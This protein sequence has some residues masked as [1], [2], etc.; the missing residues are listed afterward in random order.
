LIGAA[1]LNDVAKNYNPAQIQRLP[2]E[3]V[4]ELRP[5]KKG[6]K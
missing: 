1:L 4:F 5:T 3:A 2:K 6:V